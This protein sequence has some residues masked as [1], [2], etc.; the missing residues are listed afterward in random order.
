MEPAVEEGGVEVDAGQAA[1]LDGTGMGG[2][3]VVDG[4]GAPVLLSTTVVRME[5][6]ASDLLDGEF[7]RAERRVVE[8]AEGGEGP[9]VA[10]PGGEDAGPDRVFD[11]EE[12]ED[13][14]EQAVGEEVESVE[15]VGNDSSATGI[16]VGVG[17]DL[18]LPLA[19]LSLHGL[20]AP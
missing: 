11:G 10:P 9:E 17:G 7:V 8:D 4:A 5:R 6:M 13:V 20:L 19:S 2:D 12:G 3:N 16:W 14:N 1:A 18:S 15:A